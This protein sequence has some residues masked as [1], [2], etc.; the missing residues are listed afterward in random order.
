MAEDKGYILVVDDVQENLQVVGSILR[1]ENYKIGFSMSGEQ[2]LAQ[3]KIRLPEL[4]L[5]DVQMP[6]LNG[7]EVCK[8]LKADDATKDVPVIFLTAMS[9]IDNMTEGYDVGGADYVTKPFN[10]PELLHR[11]ETNLTLSRVKKEASAT[12]KR[13]SDSQA[14]S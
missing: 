3:V 10:P 9:E 1:K 7:Y 2:A 8:R 6:G 11:I 14:N 13:L 4:I 12:K 5:L